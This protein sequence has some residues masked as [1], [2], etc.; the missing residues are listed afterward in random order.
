ML[1]GPALIEL[2]SRIDL[3]ASAN[4]TMVARMVRNGS[5]AVDRQGRVGRY[6]LAGRLLLDF[7]RIRGDVPGS[8]W[9]GAL[10]T[11]VLAHPGP[12]RVQ[13]ERL[14]AD[15]IRAGYREL[16]PGVLVAVEDLTSLL[17]DQA[18]LVHVIPGLLE[19]GRDQAQRIVRSA[20]HVD[21]LRSE[22]EAL[23]VELERGGWTPCRP[24]AAGRR[25]SCCCIG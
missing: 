24:D 6:R 15:A 19:T 17:V 13:G 1:P 7:E 11:L 21:R 5:L 22:G 25:P 16:H 14:R 20:W 2:M 18:A 9:H 4:R 12:G 23:I 10:H 3:T 8:T